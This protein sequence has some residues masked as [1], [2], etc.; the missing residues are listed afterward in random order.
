M[1][2]TFNDRFYYYCQFENAFYFLLLSTTCDSHELFPIEIMIGW[3]SILLQFHLLLDALDN[4]ALCLD[5]QRE[6]VAHRHR[7]DGAQILGHIE[8]RKDAYHG[9]ARATG[10]VAKFAA[11]VVVWQQVMELWPEGFRDEEY[12]IGI[13]GLETLVYAPNEVR[14]VHQ[15]AHI[16]HNEIPQPEA[17]KR[18]HAERFAK[19]L[20]GRVHGQ[21]HVEP[22]IE[23]HIVA[24][25]G[26]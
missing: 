13:G 7:G 5:G 11:L 22:N 23:Q 19:V 21:Q 3:Q 10:I 8:G 18:G 26:G 16:Q 14:R 25:G 17:H 15:I 6:A 20:E 1:C 12:A 2:F 4:G 9:G 24:V